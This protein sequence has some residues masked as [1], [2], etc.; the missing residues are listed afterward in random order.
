[1]INRGK[2]KT[3]L[4]VCSIVVFILYFIKSSHGPLLKNNIICTYIYI[5]TIDR[6]IMLL[7]CGSGNGPLGFWRAW[8]VVKSV[9]WE[10]RDISRMIIF[11]KWTLENDWS[12]GFR[13]QTKTTFAKH[14]CVRITL[15]YSALTNTTVKKSLDV[16]KYL[17]RCVRNLL[18]VGVAE[19]PNSFY[20]LSCI[21]EYTRPVF[22]IQ[23]RPRANYYWNTFPTDERIRK[24]SKLFNTAN[25]CKGYKKINK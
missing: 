18:F 17:V 7:D 23:K 4:P 6:R 12:N 20:T 9:E 21:E 11:N 14:N 1:M 25:L 24:T 5:G 22:V 16:L 10:R 8:K 2:K 13:K 15:D 3:P 19:K